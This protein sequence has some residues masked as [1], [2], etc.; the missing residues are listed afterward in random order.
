M[1]IRKKNHFFYS[2]FHTY[3]STHTPPHSPNNTIQ[4]P[5]GNS[6]TLIQLFLLLTPPH[7]LLHTYSTTQPQRHV[8][9]PGRNHARVLPAQPSCPCVGISLVRAAK[10]ASLHL[11]TLVNVCAR[12]LQAQPS[13]PCVGLALVRAA[14]KASLHLPTLVNEREDKNRKTTQ[15]VKNHYPH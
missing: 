6:D 15:A 14:E 9:S 11:P 5:D 13:R 8:P 10:K 7:M 1:V 3:S 2:L 4:A 12:V